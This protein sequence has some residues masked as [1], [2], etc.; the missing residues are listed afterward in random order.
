MMV[1]IWGYNKGNIGVLEKN[2][3]TTNMWYIFGSENDLCL[4]TS[5][6]PKQ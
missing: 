5:W 2:K 1:M 4:L 3:E 6:Q